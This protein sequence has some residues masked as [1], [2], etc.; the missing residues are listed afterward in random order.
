M[1]NRELS[2]VLLS[3]LSGFRFGARLRG[4]AGSKKLDKSGTEDISWAFYP[5]NDTLHYR[6]FSNHVSPHM[7]SLFPSVHENISKK[8][9]KQIYFTFKN[10][11]LD[12]IKMKKR[13]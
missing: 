12:F 2:S 6:S 11:I 9:R 5:V 13:I 8:D 4:F 7:Q 1:R 10:F 3:A